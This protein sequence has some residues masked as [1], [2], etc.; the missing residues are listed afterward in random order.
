M[1]VNMGK[2]KKNELLIRKVPLKMFIEQL[3]D[4]WYSGTDYIDLESVNEEGDDKR[5]TINIMVYEEYVNT[6]DFPEDDAPEELADDD[7]N[8]L[9]Q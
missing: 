6:G 2:K 1:Y 5:D 3:V 7:I 9:L 4:L 8:S